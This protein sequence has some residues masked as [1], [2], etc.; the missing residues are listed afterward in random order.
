[1]SFSNRIVFSCIMPQLLRYVFTKDN[2]DSVDSVHIPVMMCSG[3]PS[4]ALYDIQISKDMVKKKLGKL[5]EDKAPV[6]DEL[7]SRLLFHLKEQLD[8]SLCILIRKSVDGAS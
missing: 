1:M 7:S 4:K 3:N 5:I 8:V 2:V 6:P